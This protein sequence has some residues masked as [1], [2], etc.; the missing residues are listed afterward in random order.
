[1]NNKRSV[2]LLFLF[3]FIASS[4]QASI[5]SFGL[6]S[7]SPNGGSVFSLPAVQTPAPPLPIQNTFPARGDPLHPLVRNTTVHKTPASLRS[8][9]PDP[10]E[11][12]LDHLVA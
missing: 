8:I 9:T 5:V 6:I 3:A 10:Y 11:T 12:T 2:K 1:M 7:Y 4:V